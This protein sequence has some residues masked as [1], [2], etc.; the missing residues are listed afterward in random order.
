MIST[1]FKMKPIHKQSLKQ[2]DK[3]TE[4]AHTATAVS[5]VLEEEDE[6]GGGFFSVEDSWDTPN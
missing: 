6:E 4:N 3:Y 1:E 2:I 5:A